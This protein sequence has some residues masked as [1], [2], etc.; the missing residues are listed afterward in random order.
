MGGP[1]RH[2]NFYKRVWQPA[3]QTAGI[4]PGFRVHDLR[5]TCA[6]LLI[7]QEAHIKAVQNHLGHSS[8]RSR[9]ITTGTFTKPIWNSLPPDWTPLTGEASATS[10]RA[11]FGGN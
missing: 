6:A 1:L 3:L 10:R 2:Q 7:T 8:I 4:K 5:H 11:A 9:W